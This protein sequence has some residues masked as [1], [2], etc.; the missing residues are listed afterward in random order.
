[1]PVI[2]PSIIALGSAG[3]QAYTGSQQKKQGQRAFEKAMAERPQYQISDTVKA[4]LAE[5]QARYNAQ[6]PAIAMAYQ[7]AQQGMANQQANIQRNAG[8]GFSALAGG[9]AAQAQLQSIIPQLAAQQTA[10]QQ[11]Q[12]A[13]LANS[14]ALMAQ[15]EKNRYSDML[16][17]NQM[18]Q[19]FGLGLA[20]A[21]SAMQSQGL[22]AGIQAA[23][24]LAAAGLT[25]NANTN[26]PQPTEISNINYIG[27][28]TGSTPSMPTGM[29]KSTLTST[30]TSSL[31]YNGLPTQASM[32]QIKTPSLP[33]GFTGPQQAPPV[34]FMNRQNIPAMNPV[35]SNGLSS[36]GPTSPNRFYKP[37]GAYTSGFPNTIGNEN[38][39][40]TPIYPNY[41]S[42]GPN[43]Y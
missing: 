19:N 38:A 30:P 4:Q 14:Q 40:Q 24:N 11:Q 8:S 9:A 33:V 31:T 23:G 41:G 2:I 27:S 26:A 43:P 5:S 6:N 17:A 10:F 20:Q 34:S 1:M 18:K 28:N 22:S 15:E 29:Y 13:N 35:Q 7:Q 21:G 12:Q 36:Q 3:Y 39:F 37:F 16:A 32:Q 25:A 42:V